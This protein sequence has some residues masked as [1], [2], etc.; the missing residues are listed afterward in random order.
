MNMQPIRA[1]NLAWLSKHGFSVA[2]HLPVERDAIEAL[3]PV[4]E[5]AARLMALDIVF[6]WVSAPEAAAATAKLQAAVDRNNLELA[7]SSSEQAIYRKERAAAHDGH[8]D[9]IGWRLENMWPLAWVLG[10]EP[11]PPLDGVMIGSDIVR[12]IIF[13]FLPKLG[14]P[15]D[16]LVARAKV[17]SF[18]DV[19]RLE[20]RFYCCHNA[21]RSAQLGG[22][23][24]PAGFH[25]VA[26]G[27]VIHERRH[28]LTWCL[29]PGTSWDDTD[30]ST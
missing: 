23:T 17:R 15:V 28:A 18:E 29:S 27:G 3:R 21:V 14:E 22:N 10:F 24:V 30:V 5:I 8:V 4:D 6:T 2:T 7:M 19:V 20:D 12:S 13:D 1:D 26:N 16:A 11:P 25:P 9:Q